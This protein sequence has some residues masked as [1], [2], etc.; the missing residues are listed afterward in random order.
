MVRVAKKS[1]SGF[2][3]QSVDVE[4][5]LQEQTLHLTSSNINLHKSELADLCYR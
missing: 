1:F 4:E 2:I 3:G 5:K